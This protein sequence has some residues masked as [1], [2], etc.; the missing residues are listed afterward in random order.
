MTYPRN[1]DLKISYTAKKLEFMY[2][3]KRN[4]AASVPISTFMCLWTIYIFP[5][6]G[7]LF[8]CSR[9]G[10]PIRGI[11]KT[12]K[13]TWMQELGLKLRSSFPGNNC[14]AFSVLI[15]YSVDNTLGIDFK[16]GSRSFKLAILH[17]QPMRTRT[18]PRS[19]QSFHYVYFSLISRIFMYNTCGCHSLVGHIEKSTKTRKYGGV[20]VQF[21]FG[22]FL[23]SWLKSLPWAHSFESLMEVKTGF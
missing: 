15:L 11:Y 9:I 22:M 5:R 17:S 10:R 12:L 7:H 19:A 21:G 18:R 13:E 6:S 1:L 16:Y 8:S 14:F 3:P 23:R 4:C 2:S 20:Y